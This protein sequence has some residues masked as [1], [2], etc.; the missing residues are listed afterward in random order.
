MDTAQSKLGE[1]N[2]KAV[3]LSTAVTTNSGL[4]NTAV[5]SWY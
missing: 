1:A 5:T 3:E 2:T 4:K